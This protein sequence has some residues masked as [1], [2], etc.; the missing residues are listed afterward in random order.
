LAIGLLATMTLKSAAQERFTSYENSYAGKTYDIQISAKEKEKFTLYIDALSLDK[1][2][3]KGGISISQKN[4]QDFLNAIAEAKIKYEEWVNTAK[5][6]NVTELDKTMTVKSKAG[7][8]FLYGTKWQFQFSV[9]LKFDFKILESNGETKYLLIVRTGELQSSSNQ[10]M[11]V[12]GFVLVFS[13][14]KEID[15]FSNAISIDKITEFS[16]KPKKEDLFKN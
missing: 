15:D 1:M 3:D 7:G 14:S 11:K 4:H 16:N 9:N 6:N 2:H 12:D 13:S 8:Y 10:F 5:E